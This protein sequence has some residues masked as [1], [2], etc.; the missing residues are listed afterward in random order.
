MATFGLGTPH[1][2]ITGSSVVRNCLG[3]VRNCLRFA[4]KI[5][6]KLVHLLSGHGHLL[7]LRADNDCMIFE[8][9]WDVKAGIAL[10]KVTPKEARA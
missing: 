5:N 7:A 10:R 9:M 6:L 8:E 4:H 1:R 2:E 3:F